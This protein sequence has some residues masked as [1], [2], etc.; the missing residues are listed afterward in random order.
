ME[1]LQKLLVL[2]SPEIGFA[3]PHHMSRSRYSNPPIRPI[4]SQLNQD[5]NDKQILVIN[6]MYYSMGM[7]FEHIIGA[8]YF[9]RVSRSNSILE[10]VLQ[11]I[12]D[13]PGQL[14]LLFLSFYS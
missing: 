4:H 3:R 14:R 13:H 6:V 10:Q 9:H 11:Y 12:F 2:R 5:K 7:L 8:T 1:L